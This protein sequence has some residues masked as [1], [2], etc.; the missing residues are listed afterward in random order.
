M[1]LKLVICLLL[2]VLLLNCGYS[3]T[4]DSITANSNSFTNGSYYQIGI[5]LLYNA[6][7]SVTDSGEDLDLYVLV[8][9]YKPSL[10]G[11][12]GFYDDIYPF[13]S[14]NLFGI[15]SL[16]G[17]FTLES[18]SYIYFA[19]P[20]SSGYRGNGIPKY[21]SEEIIIYNS[22]DSSINDTAKAYCRL[23][24]FNSSISSGYTYS[25]T[26]AGGIFYY[27]NTTSSNW[28][29]V[30]Y[31]SSQTL[32]IMHQTLCSIFD[33][34]KAY[35]ISFLA[36]NVNETFTSNNYTFYITEFNPTF[37]G[38]NE[39]F[40]YDDS[41]SIT[42]ADQ[43]TEF[44]GYNSTTTIK[45]TKNGVSVGNST[46]LNLTNIGIS[47]NDTIAVSCDIESELGS[48]SYSDSAIVQNYTFSVK[49]NSKTSV[50]Y[51]LGTNSVTSF[52]L[53]IKSDSDDNQAY[54]LTDNMNA[55]YG[56]ITY[57]Q[58]NFNLSSTDIKYVEMNITTGATLINNTMFN[59][60][61]T[62]TIDSA[63]SNLLFDLSV[64]ENIAVLTISPTTWS[65]TFNTDQTASKVFTLLSTGY[66]ANNCSFTATDSSINS[67]LSSTL[68]DY[69]NLSDGTSTNAT[70]SLSGLSAGLYTGTI[71]YSCTNTS[72]LSSDAEVIKGIYYIIL[73]STPT[74][75]GGGGSGGGS[76]I[77]LN[78]NKQSCN[79]DISVEQIVLDDNT[80]TQSVKIKN[81]EAFGY[82]PE[83]SF[84]YLTGNQELIDKLRQSNTI[85][86][87]DTSKEAVTG[88]RLSLPVPIGTATG[89]VIISSTKCSDIVIP[90][91]VKI[92]EQTE[93]VNELSSFLS[94]DKSFSE[95]ID[96]LRTKY[97]LFESDW[98]SVLAI[99]MYLS[100]LFM[101]WKIPRKKRQIIEFKQSAIK[102][103]LI[104]LVVLVVQ[105]VIAFTLVFVTQPFLI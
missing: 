59:I 44:G 101:F 35:N 25:A 97:V 69:F 103:I 83:L 1:R 60:T 57:N 15:N 95:R 90:I 5:E 32:T 63:T 42:C 51:T 48:A 43:T 12:G 80:L 22:A 93:I 36:E 73:V 21:E 66:D 37:S 86:F 105:V 14:Y 72:D 71:I 26:R 100:L 68:T 31:V 4:L 98:S 33:E 3:I 41:V 58:S 91:E 34:T 79:I 17:S 94:S 28:E 77:D 38:Y 2:S 54:T 56:S 8:N 74:T 50:E 10:K 104:S 82:D 6:T 92:T 18:P 24:G 84:K 85:E 46:I 39:L 49:Q 76:T 52:T 55:L 81:N 62:R 75:S 20:Q 40:V 65:T 78:D 16:T 53:Q 61:L 11:D 30:S 47:E 87:I 27:Y 67:S 13:Q 9:G 29:N 89:Q 88:V 19:N 96:E 23:K 7:F 64:L 102:Y 99:M 45:W 70:I